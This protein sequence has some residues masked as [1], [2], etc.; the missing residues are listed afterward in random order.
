MA[1]PVSAGALPPR[2]APSLPQAADTGSRDRRQHRARP[3]LPGLRGEGR[4]G[5]Q[6]VC[7][8]MSLSHNS[9]AERS[10]AASG[11]E[12]GGSLRLLFLLL[13]ADAELHRHRERRQGQPPPRRNFGVPGQDPGSSHRPSPVAPPPRLRDPPRWGGPRGAYYRPPLRPQRRPPWLPSR[14]FPFFLLPQRREEGISSAPAFPSSLSLP[15]GVAGRGSGPE[16]G[17][18]ARVWFHSLP[19]S[20]GGLCPGIY[21]AV[22]P[23]RPLC[24]GAERW[25]RPG[26]LRLPPPSA[27]LSAAAP[28]E[29]LPEPFR[30]QRLGSREAGREGRP[31]GRRFQRD[32][33]SCSQRLVRTAA[34]RPGADRTGERNALSPY[35][36]NK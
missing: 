3:G 32:P 19:A 24:P 16:A 21:G 17:A 14:S 33:G 4:D 35:E 10:G 23:P 26:R 7:V 2:P 12:T 6:G 9:P 25:C 13:L 1:A 28:P 31:A 5:A 20:E 27:A 15:Q 8:C 11:T 34:A 18:V 30:Q 36:E 22:F 29:T